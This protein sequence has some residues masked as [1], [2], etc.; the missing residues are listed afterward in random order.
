MTID[1]VIK[2]LPLA[3]AIIVGLGIL[4]TAVY[5]GYFGVNII[6]YL[7]PSDVLSCFR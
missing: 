2:I 6:S 5:Y 4:K 7:A 1:K 3:T